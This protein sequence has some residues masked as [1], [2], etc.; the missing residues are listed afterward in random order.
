QRVRLDRGAGRPGRET[1][2]LRALRPAQAARREVRHRTRLRQPEVRRGPGARCR[3]GA[4]PRRAHRVLRGR[5]GELRVDPQPQRLRAHREEQTGEVDR[6][7]DRFAT[8]REGMLAEI[9]AVYAETLDYTGLAAMSPQVRAA[10]GKVE[11]HRL[12]PAAQAAL[13]YRNH[14]LPIGNGQTISQPYIVA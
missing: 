14:P 1:G 12:L 5:V 8:A 11:R 9:D 3:R 13:A 2:L 6:A 10:M 7:V 4:Q